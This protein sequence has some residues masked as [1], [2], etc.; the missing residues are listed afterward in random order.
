MTIEERFFD[1]TWT[2]R[3]V[4]PPMPM[5]QQSS[6]NDAKGQSAISVTRSRSQRPQSVAMNRWW[7]W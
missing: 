7:G 1:E 3:A 5:H 2:W 4:F 6:Q